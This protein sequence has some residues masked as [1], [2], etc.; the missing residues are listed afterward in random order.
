MTKC[1]YQGPTLLPLHTHVHFPI[2]VMSRHLI[3]TDCQVYRSR[4]GIWRPLSYDSK[5]TTVTPEHSTLSEK[6]RSILLYQLL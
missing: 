3:F 2:M 4:G 1:L 6:Y 5:T